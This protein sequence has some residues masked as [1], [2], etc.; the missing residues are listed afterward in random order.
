[1][2]GGEENKAVGGIGA[3]YFLEMIPRENGHVDKK[4]SLFLTD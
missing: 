1:M 4:P 2:L 3:A